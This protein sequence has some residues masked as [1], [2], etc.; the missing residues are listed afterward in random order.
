MGRIDRSRGQDATLERRYINNMLNNI[1]EYELVKNGLHSE[2]GRVAEFYRTRKICKQNFLK[3][4]R[5]YINFGRDINKLLPQKNGRKFKDAIEYHPEV[6]DKLKELRSKGYNRYEIALLLR[7]L[8]NIE[9][10]SSCVY[11]PIPLIFIEFVMSQKIKISRQK[12]IFIVNLWK[13]FLTK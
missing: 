13:K 2:F 4:Y 3:Y 5:R 7:K 6:I 1:E 12:F 10:S 9:L 11:E 8:Q